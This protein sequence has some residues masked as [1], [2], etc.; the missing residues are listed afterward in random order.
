MFFSFEYFRLFNAGG[1][2]LSVGGVRDFSHILER[3]GKVETF[4]FIGCMV[5][6]EVNGQDILQPFNNN[7]QG[8]TLGCGRASGDQCGSD[9]CSNRG[10]CLNEWTSTRCVC[11]K[12]YAGEQCEHGKGCQYGNL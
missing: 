11:N 3:A 6:V 12:G 1:N 8:V 4:N 9:S 7:G 2:K 5:S 10:V